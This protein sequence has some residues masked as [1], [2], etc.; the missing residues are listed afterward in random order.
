MDLWSR[1][2]A[3]SWCIPM[4]LPLM[5]L[6]TSSPITESTLVPTE[7]QTY[8]YA[9]TISACCVHFLLFDVF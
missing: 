2:E 3:L 5:D 7:G 6:H 4:L 8:E 9:K 1:V